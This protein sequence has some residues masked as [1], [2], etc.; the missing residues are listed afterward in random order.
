MLKL[1][2]LSAIVA[3]PLVVAALFLL[4]V[5]VLAG[6]FLVLAG[7]GAWEWSRLVP[8][9]GAAATIG[10]LG[11]QG[12]AAAL[13]WAEPAATVPFLVAG[14][15]TWAF[16]IAAVLGFPRSSAWLTRGLL[17]AAGWLVIGGAWLGLVVV[18][19]QPLGAWWLLWLFV[20]VWGADIGAYFAGR[21]FGRR[22]LAPAVSPGK[23]WEGVVGGLVLALAAGSLLVLLSPLATLDSSLVTW[24]ALMV[25][26]SAVSVFGDLFESVLKRRRGVK[27]SGT[28]FPGHGGVLDRIDSLLAALPVL[29]LLLAI[30]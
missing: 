9:D 16:A 6:V 5:P 3:A 27:D 11:V 29:G 13:L 18:A 20:L 1:R 8:V 14:C 30:A 25:L 17:A 28:L 15:A 23:T 2:V 12:A 10:Y 19:S 7:L 22:K 26:L 4:P 21:R 24:L